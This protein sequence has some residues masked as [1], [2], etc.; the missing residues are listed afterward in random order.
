MVFAAVVK[1]PSIVAVQ[2]GK[3]GHAL[4]RRS[5]GVFR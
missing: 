1:R 4:R 2:S 5:L 3:N